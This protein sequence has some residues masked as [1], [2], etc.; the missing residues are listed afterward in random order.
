MFKSL[1]KRLTILCGLATSFIMTIV[2]ILLFLFS[3]NQTVQREKE[4]FDTNL[5]SLL[6]KVKYSNMISHDYLKNM[7]LDNNL[8]IY[9]EN[10]GHPLLYEG[11]FPDKRT[12]DI[13]ISD[14][15]K[16]ALKE[17]IN[18][19]SN[20]ITSNLTISSLYKFKNN[21]T[22]YKAVEAIV[23]LNNGWSSLILINYIPNKNI[24]I[25]K[26]VILFFLI[27]VLACTMLFIISKIFIG[28]AIKP[29]EENQCKHL[30]F[31]AAAS[32]ELRSPLTVINASL[33]CLKDYIA[34]NKYITN[35]ENESRRMTRLINDML[36]L[37]N[38][39]AKNWTLCEEN[40]EMDTLLIEIY[41]LFYPIATSYN[42]SLFLDLPDERLYF[43]RG[44]K[45][46]IKQILT[47]LIDNAIEYTSEDGLI[48]IRA[49]ND[50]HYLHIELIDNGIGITDEQK[51]KI[52]NR[53]YRG[54][55]SRSSKKHFGLGLNIALELIKLHNGN[56]YVKDTIGGGA[57]FH[58][59]LPI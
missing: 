23:P 19:S 40:V 53:F 14:V 5:N 1:K 7:E 59:E 2:I 33:S 51:N 3:F 41:D 18:S 56:I 6:E 36:L 25:M 42:K 17:G 15:K 28:K 58:I 22:Y 30:E 32:H 31:I 39:D 13:L 35:I 49:H 54:D 57:T 21:T 9:I 43:V 37:A 55:K 47:I 46:R 27:D 11:T 16:Y 44:D 4:I 38:S 24:K 20:P 45:E 8:I 29:V 10:D 52:F 34:T 48:T 50:V 12:K 26:L